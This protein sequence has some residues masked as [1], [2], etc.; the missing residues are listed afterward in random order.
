MTCVGEMLRDDARGAGRACYANGVCVH[1]AQP[2]GSRDGNTGI[3]TFKVCFTS[4]TEDR[5]ER[6]KG[7]KINPDWK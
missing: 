3:F 5:L 1:L 7:K 2:G 4:N 6:I